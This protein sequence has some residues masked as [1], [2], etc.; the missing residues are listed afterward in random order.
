[1][2][3]SL[4]SFIPAAG[5]WH[6]SRLP[7]GVTEGKEAAGPLRH[8]QLMALLSTVLNSL[9]SGDMEFVTNDF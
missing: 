8:G 9:L 6:L 4:V 3:L 5:P 7:D 1:M 2:C